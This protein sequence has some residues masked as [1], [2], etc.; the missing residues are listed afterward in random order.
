[1]TCVIK[2]VDKYYP[3]L[4]LEGYMMNK[5]NTKHLKKRYAKI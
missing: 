5:H 2:D 3:E 4:F 1:M